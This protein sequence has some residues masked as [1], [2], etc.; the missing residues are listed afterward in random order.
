MRRV[1]GLVHEQQE[2]I[3][4]SPSNKI[5]QATLG[6]TTD[7]FKLARNQQATV[8]CHACHGPK[9][10]PLVGKRDEPP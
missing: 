1:N 9:V 7:A 2:F 3:V 4:G 5:L 10:P 6:E 8:Q